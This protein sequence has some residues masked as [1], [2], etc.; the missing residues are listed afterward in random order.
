MIS[1]L[2]A[3][4]AIE[5]LNVLSID[6]PLPVGFDLWRS[7][8]LKPRSLTG[9]ATFALH[10]NADELEHKTG[11]QHIDFFEKRLLETVKKLLEELDND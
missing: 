4:E 10:I 1:T 8:K 9:F 7:D 5:L 11:R 2:K 3:H 6:L